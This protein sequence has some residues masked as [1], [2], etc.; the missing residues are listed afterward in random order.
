MYNP[1]SFEYK[2][3]ERTKAVRKQMVDVKEF[4]VFNVCKY[5]KAKLPID[6]SSD[7][8]ADIEMSNKKEPEW[9][10][11]ELLLKVLVEGSA[12]LYMYE[13]ENFIR[14]FY[15]LGDSLTTQLIYKKYSQPGEID[16]QY[17]KEYLNQLSLYV[18]CNFVPIKQ[19]ERINYSENDLIKYFKKYNNCTSGVAFTSLPD[20]KKRKWFY[21]KPLVGIG[22]SSFTSGSA[23]DGNIAG[24][25]FDSR[26]NF[27]AGLETEFILPFRKN[28]WSVFL[29]GSTFSYKANGKN[30]QGNAAT[31]DYNSIV[32]GMGLRYNLF[33]NDNTKVFF[34]VVIMKDIKVR[35]II[36]NP[37]LGIGYAYKRFSGELRVSLRKSIYEYYYYATTHPSFI[38][39]SFTI[40][41]SVF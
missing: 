28:A 8:M 21:L 39:G 32:L 33:L 31:V 29:D 4:S 34:N 6:R 19:I 9:Q 13:E 22:Y 15:K 14:F 40:K 1:T 26:K 3:N 25:K 37:A 5:V 12:T 30:S 35:Q 41:Y 16:F 27:S 38:N 7:L 18:N 36:L 24:I 20:S 11:E 17:N 23:I 10:E 2:I